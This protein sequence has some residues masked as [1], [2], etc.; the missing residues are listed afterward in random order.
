MSLLAAAATVLS[1]SVAWADIPAPFSAPP[2][3]DDYRISYSLE[4]GI[5]QNEE[6]LHHQLAVQIP[7]WSTAVGALLPFVNAFGEVN[8]S[9]M[10]NMRLYVQWFHRFSFGSRT[11]LTVGGGVDVYFPTAT[12]FEEAQPHAPLIA[13]PMAGETALF[14]PELTFATRPRVHVG[15]E[16]WIFCLQAFAG[17]GVHFV[18][19]EAMVAFEWGANLATSIV[20]WLT[21]AVEITGAAWLTDEPWWMEQRAVFIAGGLRFLLPHGLEPALWVRGSL[22]T[23]EHDW[24]WAPFVGVNLTWRHDR[25]WILF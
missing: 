13:A 22:I 2:A 10:G 7:I 20:D 4:T 23:P 5:W 21:V 18:G 3:E 19:S 16:L 12:P 6:T 8:D 14:A 9:L 11:G 17:A 25:D 24:G 1:C 15:G